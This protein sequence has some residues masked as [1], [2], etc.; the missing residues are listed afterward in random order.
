MKKRALLTTVMFLLIASTAQ[1]EDDQLGV[2]FDLTY[3]SRWMSRGRPVWSDTGGF[4]ETIDLDLYGTGLGAAV[5]HRSATSSDWVNKQRFDYTFYYGGTVLDGQGDSFF[6]SGVCCTQFKI[7]WIYK[8]WYDNP[9][10]KSNMRQLDPT[11]LIL[12]ES[13]G[14]AHGANMYL[15]YEYEPTKFNGSHRL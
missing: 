6:T 8:H 12:D 11:S 14:W 15:T 2:T 13:C 9:R 7:N 10:N 3:A 4:F 5:T 1:A